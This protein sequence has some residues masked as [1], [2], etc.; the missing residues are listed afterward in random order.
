[1]AKRAGELIARTLAGSG[2][3]RLVAV[4]LELRAQLVEAVLDLLPGVLAC[5]AFH[6]VSRKRAQGR[7]AEQR[8]LASLVH[9]DAELDRRAARLLGQQRDFHAVLQRESLRARV[10]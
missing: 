10:E 2:E 8:F 3:R 7:F 9:L 1:E 6:H 5:P 4:D